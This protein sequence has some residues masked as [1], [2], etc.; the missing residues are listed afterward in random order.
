MRHFYI[1]LAALLLTAALCLLGSESLHGRAE[2]LCDNVCLAKS[3]WEA[4][5][6]QAAKEVICRTESD[7]QAQARLFSA[8]W[9]HEAVLQISLAFRELANSKGQDFPALCDRLMLELTRRAELERPYWH[10]I[11]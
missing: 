4:G 6:T 2:Q 1:G 10:N 3:E 8:L 11:L 7:W 9:N 5:R